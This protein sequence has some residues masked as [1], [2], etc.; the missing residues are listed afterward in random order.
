MPK[1]M[2]FLKKNYIQ[3]LIGEDLTEIFK[4][5]IDFSLLFE[6]WKFFNDNYE[7]Y[8]QNLFVVKLKYNIKFKINS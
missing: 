3:S 6:I 2:K 4:E 1:I 7:Q 5:G 8:F